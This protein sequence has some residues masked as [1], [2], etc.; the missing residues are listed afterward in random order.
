MTKLTNLNNGFMNKL[1]VLAILACLGIALCQCEKSDGNNIEN[2]GNSTLG[3]IADTLT[4]Q[5]HTNI[6]MINKGDTS[7]IESIDGSSVSGKGERVRLLR[8]GGIIVR[9]DVEMVDADGIVAR[10]LVVD[11]TGLV[12]YADSCTKLSDGAFK[13]HI[14]NYYP[15]GL[16]KSTGWAVSRGNDYEKIG[17]WT[18][19]DANGA[20]Q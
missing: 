20:I 9:A 5:E 2:A 15:N 6:S 16:V 14:I 8:Q 1:S 3:C 7:W 13:Y 18:H 4:L 12:M 10:K 11:T 17:A 19:Y